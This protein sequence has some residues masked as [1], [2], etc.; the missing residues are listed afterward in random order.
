[1]HHTS[2]DFYSWF[3]FAPS[4]PTPT[5]IHT[6][7]NSI[8]T[9]YTVKPTDKKNASTHLGRNSS[10]SEFIICQTMLS[11]RL[12]VLSRV[13][14]SVRSTVM[15]IYKK[16]FIPLKNEA[17]LNNSIVQFHLLFCTGEDLGLT[18]MEEHRLKVNCC[19]FLS[20]FLILLIFVMFEL[21]DIG[22]CK[23]ICISLIILSSETFRQTVDWMRLRES[24]GN[25]LHPRKRK[26]L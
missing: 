17:R 7:I 2:S 6:I 4:R 21:T 15:Q 10:H 23:R 1:M 5:H 25:H 3:Q 14:V 22:K 12:G 13:K 26:Q 24:W 18:W 16:L 19:I 20:I 9:S 8:P 11:W